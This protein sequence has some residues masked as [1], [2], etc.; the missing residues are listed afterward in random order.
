MVRRSELL[1]STVP[2]PIETL[3]I[4]RA[5]QVVKILYGNAVANVYIP[6][7]TVWGPWRGNELVDI[8]WDELIRIRN[9]A[10]DVYGDDRLPRDISIA[11]YIGPMTV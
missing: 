6:H 5:S 8:E 10:L 4:D 2:L 7:G 9:H 11:E 1:A 3:H